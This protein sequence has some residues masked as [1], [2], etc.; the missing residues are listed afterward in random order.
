MR[1]FS[2]RTLDTISVRVNPTF[3][4][5]R[6][7]GD[8]EKFPSDVLGDWFKRCLPADLP[9]IG[10]EIVHADRLW[11]VTGIRQLLQSKG[12]PKGDKLPVRF[13]EF[14]EDL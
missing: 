13:C 7:E 9:Q 10:W 5:F 4:Y 14:I 1:N 12:S 2:G 8:P 11:R 3:V 6:F